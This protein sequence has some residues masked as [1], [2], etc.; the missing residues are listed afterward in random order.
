MVQTLGP[1]S[2]LGSYR[3]L[4]LVNTGQDAQLWQAMSDR[5]GKFVGIKTF[6]D[7]Q[8]HEKGFSS[9]VSLMRWEYK[10]GSSL[11]HKNIITMMEY[12]ED[13]RP[14]LVME[15]F[16]GQN[17]KTLIRGGVEAQAYRASGLI[18]A[19]LEAVGYMNSQGWVHRDIKPDNFL[20]SDTDVVKLI[21]FAISHRKPGFM[22]RLFGGRCPVQGTRSY[23]SPEQIRGQ[24]VDQRAD[25][26]SLG[27]TIFEL[28]CGRP[29]FTGASQN[30]LLHK[31]LNATPPSV[32][33]YNSNV[34]SDFA[35]LLRRM[36]AKKPQDRPASAEECLKEM[37]SMRVF[38]KTPLRPPL[39]S[40]RSEEKS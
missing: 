20:V 16:M 13:P 38:R 14:F 18:Q 35:K 5:T 32:E 26:Y 8:M 21:D 6:S 28:L 15:W 24:A 1:Q 3:L 7:K 12:S 4:N 11:K 2:Y 29:P 39:A 22:S 31:H 19:A 37:L 25:L 36:L 17:M 27:C 30:E 33:A 34:S 23:M 40:P 9:A 10:V